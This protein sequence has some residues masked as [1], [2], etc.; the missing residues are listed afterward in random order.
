MST[1]ELCM[2]TVREYLSALQAQFTFLVLQAILSW[3]IPVSKGEDAAKS[4]PSNGCILEVQ[5]FIDAVDK[6]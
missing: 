5:Q 3:R 1:E 2:D 6:N 4:A